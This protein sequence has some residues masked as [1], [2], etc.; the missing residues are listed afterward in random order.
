VAKINI[1]VGDDSRYVAVCCKDA[2]VRTVDTELQTITAELNI[3]STSRCYISF[4]A[5]TMSVLVHCNDEFVNI[6][7]A[8]DGT[9]YS[10]IAVEVTDIKSLGYDWELDYYVVTAANGVTLLEST[11][12][13]PVAYASKAFGYVTSTHTFLIRDS[14]Q[15]YSTKYKNYQELIEEAGGQFP[16]AELTYEEMVKYNII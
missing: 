8:G 1:V 13:Q 12:F 10:Q 16:G 9:I 5:S 11:N 7:D 6:I 4:L 3:Y 14:K 2:Y 15:V